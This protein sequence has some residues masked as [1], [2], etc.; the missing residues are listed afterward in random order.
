MRS[1]SYIVNFSDYDLSQNYHHI[2]W[3]QITVSGFLV[4]NFQAKYL[5]QFLKEVPARV[6]RGE[7]KYTEDKRHG[8]ESVGQTLYDVQ[9]GN[10]TGKAVIVVSDD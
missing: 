1:A 3:K 5:K 6:A 9:K 7:L 8:L 4:M 10:N 2:L